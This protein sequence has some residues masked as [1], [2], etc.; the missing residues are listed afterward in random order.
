M[1]VNSRNP[2]N[3]GAGPPRREE[4]RP[5]QEPGEQGDAYP[6][7][8][9]AN[10]GKRDDAREPA[11]VNKRY[12]QGG[13]TRGD[14]YRGETEREDAFRFRQFSGDGYFFLALARFCFTRNFTI[15][16]TSA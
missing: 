13:A 12:S 11:R 7:D 4:F 10:S 3:L 5:G 16:A 2:G 8:A 14:P 6:S 9:V 1:A 15:L